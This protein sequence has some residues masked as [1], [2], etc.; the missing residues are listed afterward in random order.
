[1]KEVDSY[2]DNLCKNMDCNGNEAKE[3]KREIK[4]HLLETI[5]ELQRE[6][7]S[8]EESFKIAVERFG[9]TSELRNEL[10]EV[11]HIKNPILNMLNIASIVS[12]IVLSIVLIIECK[13]ADTIKAPILIFLVPVYII[14]R[15]R[16]INKNQNGEINSMDEVL[17]FIC[18]L[19]GII[20]IGGQVFPIEVSNFGLQGYSNIDFHVL[21]LL[22]IEENINNMGL[23]SVIFSIIRAFLMYLPIGLFL[24]VISERFRKLSN[25][26]MVYI[27]GCA[28]VIM[29]KILFNVIG[30]HDRV[31]VSF[32][33]SIFRVIGITMGYMIYKKMST[34]L[35]IA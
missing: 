35:V 34:R 14:F 6:G 16:K 13:D 20:L 7:K 31:F 23:S 3:F 21:P 18:M 10:S 19:Y 15:I 29:I 28:V 2:V 32:D 33:Y 5:N 22:T 8:K 11:V 4:E 30:L 17:K 1:M 27:V 26:I 24:P 25:C 9:E 12:I